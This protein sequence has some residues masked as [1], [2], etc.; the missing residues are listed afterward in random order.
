MLVPAAHGRW[1]AGHIP[2]VTAIADSGKGHMTDPNVAIEQIRRLAFGLS[3]PTLSR[4]AG[5]SAP[6]P[7]PPS[8][9]S[10]GMCV[11]THQVSVSYDGVLPV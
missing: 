9:H 1:L 11:C 2:T 10:S 3:S 4:G 6:Q 7:R 5:L 8:V